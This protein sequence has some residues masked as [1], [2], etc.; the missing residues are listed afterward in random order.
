M[1]DK[2]RFDNAVENALF[3]FWASIASSYPE[4]VTGELDPYSATC[5]AIDAE[6]VVHEWLDLNLKETN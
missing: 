3:D 5:F 1:T 2:E 6:K 4:A